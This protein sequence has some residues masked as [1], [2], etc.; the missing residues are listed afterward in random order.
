MGCSEYYNIFDADCD[1]QDNFD[2]FNLLDLPDD[3][4]PNGVVCIGKYAFAGNWKLTNITIPDSVT[5]IGEGAFKDCCSLTKIIIPD[6]VTRIDK[7]AFKGCINLT[8]ITI[9]DSVTRIDESAFSYCKNLTDVYYIGT[10]E[11]WNA[12]KI[13]VG[14]NTRLINATI[15]FTKELKGEYVLNN[16]GESYAITG[17]GGC[18]WGTEAVVPN[19]FNGKPVTIIGNHAFSC[20][21]HLTSVTIPDSVTCIGEDAFFNCFN[22]TSV[23]IP[24]SVTCIGEDAFSYCEKLTSITIPTSVTTIGERAFSCCNRLTSVTFE[25]SNGWYATKTEGASNET[26]LT[27]TD[28]STNA[29]YLK[30]TYKYYCWYKS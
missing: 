27:L 22:L 6:S 20:C 19:E 25:D 3:L 26:T 2:I 16:D 7:G 4:I 1:S 5:C 30:S 13:N 10:E 8:S 17:T 21:W 28:A 23:T 12:I 18:F 24:D 9:S 14:G 11:Q 29:T 15:H